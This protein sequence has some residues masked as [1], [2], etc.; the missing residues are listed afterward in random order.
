YTPKPKFIGTDTFQYRAND[1][2]LSSKAVRVDI[3]VVAVN[4][5]PVATPDTYSFVEDSEISVGA[6]GV[7][8]NDRDPD[9]GTLRAELGR[10][11]PGVLANDFDNVEF[12]GV[13]VW[14]LVRAPVHGTLTL[15]PD[16]SFTYVPASGFTGR[17]GFTYRP[18]DSSPGN[19]T[20]VDIDVVDYSS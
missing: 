8:A 13:R 5:P 1:G 11:A 15:R 18:G 17:D 7:L 20:S 2:R 4:A 9:G 16:G 19:P 14:D 10:A 3:R 6:P 12:D